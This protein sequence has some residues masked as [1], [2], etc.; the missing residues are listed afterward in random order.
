VISEYEKTWG[1]KPFWEDLDG[2][3][4]RVKA[5]EERIKKLLNA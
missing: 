2:F 1:H 5:E 3:N 4:E